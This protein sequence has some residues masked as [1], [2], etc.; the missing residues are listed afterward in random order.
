[1][2]SG[3]AIAR[4]IQ[5]VRQKRFWMTLCPARDGISMS[6]LPGSTHLLRIS[7][8]HMLLTVLIKQVIILLPGLSVIGCAFDCSILRSI[9]IS[10]WSLQKFLD[11]H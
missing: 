9:N 3:T 6:T 11:A 4:W 2:T 5:V 7:A 8:F 1:M 10:Y